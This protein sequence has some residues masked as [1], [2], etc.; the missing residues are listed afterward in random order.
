MN[1][2]E[3][4]MDDASRNKFLN[5]LQIMI[6]LVKTFA[7][8]IEEIP[9]INDQEQLDM[10]KKQ[11]AKTEYNLNSKLIDRYHCYHNTILSNL[12]KIV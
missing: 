4:L 10:L 2:K 5:Q 6:G 1:N 8:L 12:N 9:E 3:L 7:E 11:I